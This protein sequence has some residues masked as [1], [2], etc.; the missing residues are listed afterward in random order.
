M[1]GRIFCAFA[2]VDTTA[3]A[4]WRG[5]SWEREGTGGNPFCGA[6]EGGGGWGEPLNPGQG[7][8]ACGCALGGNP[9]LAMGRIIGGG[10]VPGDTCLC[11][12]GP[13]GYAEDGEDGDGGG[14]C[15]GVAFGGSP[16]FI[17]GIGVN[18]CFLEG[19]SMGCLLGGG[20]YVGDDGDCG[21]CGGDCSGCSIGLSVFLAVITVFF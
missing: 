6:C 19:G 3:G 21:D 5:T 14:G 13:P 4:D 9:R 20:W 8:G 17:S 12:G 16:R 1:E 11:R 2:A 15:W 10:G 7:G 18:C